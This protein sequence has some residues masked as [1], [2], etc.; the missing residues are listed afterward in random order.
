MSPNNEFR[1]CP[2]GKWSHLG[3]ERL[4]ARSGILQYFYTSICNFS[5]SL[6]GVV[7][8]GLLWTSHPLIPHNQKVGRSPSCSSISDLPKGWQGNLI[9]ASSENHR[10]VLPILRYHKILVIYPYP[11]FGGNYPIVLLNNIY[12]WLY[13]YI[14]WFTWII[15]I[16]DFICYT[17]NW[18]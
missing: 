7:S 6:Q 18:R 8:T 3:L 14:K 10:W 4:H 13:M 9:F 16:N 12:S 11:F 15:F 5:S 17:R 2:L 1:W